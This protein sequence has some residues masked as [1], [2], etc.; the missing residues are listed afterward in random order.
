MAYSGIKGKTAIVT[1]GGEG[2][3][4]AIAEALVKNGANV[5]LND[6]DPELSKKAAKEIDQIHPGNCKSFAGDAGSI[7]TI[8]EIIDFAVNSFG[9]IHFVVPNAGITLFGDFLKFTPESFN[10]VVELNLQGAFFLVQKAVLK[11]IE[12]GHSG[13]VVLL[14]SQVGIRA[15]RNLT[16]YAM[17]KAALRMMAVNLAY[18]LDQHHININVI[19]PGATLTERTKL[20]QPDY[21]GI[22]G[23]LNPNGRVGKPEDIAHTC[24]F[25]L[26]GE[27]DHINGQTISVDGGWTTAGKY[28]EDLN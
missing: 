3:G 8:D 4:Y 26:S 13:K 19:A 28:P 7:K 16:T 14:S 12:K 27:A 15:Y 9:D 22:W 24:L 17:T 25:L 5:V 1:G 2:I 18:E 21:E 23:R 20:E 6:L 11:M 10:K